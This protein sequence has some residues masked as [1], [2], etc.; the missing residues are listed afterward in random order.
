MSHVFCPEPPPPNPLPQGEE[1][2]FLL[3]LDG[4][5]PGC[6]A[7]AG[8]AHVGAHPSVRILSNHG[9][10]ANMARTCQTNPH[11]PNRNAACAPLNR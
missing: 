11:R 8:N 3:F 10:H 6:P 2:H 1:E 4:W 9:H 7:A 5:M